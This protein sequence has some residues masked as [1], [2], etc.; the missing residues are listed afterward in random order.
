MAM[1]AMSRMSRKPGR[2]RRSSRRY[3]PWWMRITSDFLP[4][5]RWFDL[6][7]YMK[8]LKRVGKRADAFWQELLEK[9]RSGKHGN[10]TM[11]EHLLTL[12]KTQPEYYSD[13]VIKGLI[14]V[15]RCLL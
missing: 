2:S 9:H 15:L 1:M 13:Y 5:F 8:R 10:D 7:G 11:I 12:Q 4:L 14:Q 6:D 3:C